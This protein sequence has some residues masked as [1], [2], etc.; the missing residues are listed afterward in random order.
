MLGL[1]FDVKDSMSITY[2]FLMGGAFASIWKNKDKKNSKT[3][4]PLMDYNLILLT[5]PGT[6]S[7]SLFGVIKSLYIDDFKSFHIRFGNNFAF[8]DTTELFDNKLLPKN[9]IIRQEFKSIIK[10][11]FNNDHYEQIIIFKFNA[12]RLLEVEINIR[13]LEASVPLGQVK[14][15]LPHI[16]V[17]NGGAAAKRRP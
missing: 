9:A 2:I 7:G 6:I 17:H 5:L 1:G 14:D 12:L 10:K 11:T 3:G 13:I 15:N 16:C 8:C 4:N